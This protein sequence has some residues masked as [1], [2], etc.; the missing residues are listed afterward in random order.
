LGGGEAK[1]DGFD[2]ITRDLLILCPSLILIF[3]NGK[4]Q[5]G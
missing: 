2:V 5:K 3:H 1:P 4:S